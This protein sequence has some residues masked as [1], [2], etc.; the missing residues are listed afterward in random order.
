VPEPLPSLDSLRCFAEAA[1][2]LNFRAAARS[3]SLTPAALGQRIKQLED[4]LGV[5]LFHR[6]TRSVTLTEGGLSLLAYA[7]RALDAAEA[8]VRAGRG[9]VDPPPLDLTIGTRHELGMSWLV[10]MLPRLAAARPGLTLH[11]YVGSGPDLLHRVHAL[12]IDCAITST[13]LTDPK[14]EGIRL[15][16]ERYGLFGAPRL[17]RTRPMRR[18][19][20]AA[21]HT[22]ID[23]GPGMPLYRYL[24]DGL[25]DPAFGAIRYLGTLEAMRAL[26]VAGDGVAVLPVYFAAADVRARRLVRLVPRVAAAADAFR[27]VFRADDPR[28]PIYERLIELLRAE[29]LR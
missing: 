18:A 26:V 24:R 6:T 11:L 29:P 8:C 3:V 27:F 5:R 15:H 23:I 28:R 16:E 19:A 9:E 17:L 12:Q 4:Q 25:G 10:P 7:Q 21:H 14:L 22:L 1:R 2:L 13:V 20:D